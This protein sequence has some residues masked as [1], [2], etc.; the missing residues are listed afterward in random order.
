MKFHWML[1][2]NLDPRELNSFIKSI[3]DVGYDSILTTFHSDEEDYFIKAANALFEEQK[4]KYMVAIRPYA[5]TPAYLSMMIKGFDQISANKLILNVVSGT[6]DEE[7][8][9][10]ENIT[11]I[12]DRKIE[13]GKFILNLRKINDNLPAIFFSGGSDQTIHNSFNYGDGIIYLLED[14]LNNSNRFDII[15]GRKILKIFL[16]IKD[17]YAE[18]EKIF[19]DL[20]N[21]RQIKNCIYGTK[22]TVSKELNRFK[23]FELMFS[24]TYNDNS[25][26]AIHQLVREIST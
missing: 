13:S 25:D 7:Q 24:S 12:H 26:Q 19:N 11:S 5:L 15:T 22:E 10:F 23:N 9:L 14:H 4:T 2:Y 18:A 3:D 6:T 16:I 1:K 8:S 20:K 17:T 21:E